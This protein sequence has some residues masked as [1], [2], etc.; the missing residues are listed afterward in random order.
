MIAHETRGSTRPDLAPR[1]HDE[2]P[3]ELPGIALDSRLPEAA[4]QRMERRNPDRRADETVEPR[5]GNIERAVELALAVDEK[6]IRQTHRGD[7]GA[8]CLD[9][10]HPHTDRLGTEEADLVV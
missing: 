5:P 6:R 10:A 4:A 3:S 8:R 9:V 2:R 7:D 1:I